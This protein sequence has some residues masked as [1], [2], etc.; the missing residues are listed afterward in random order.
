MGPVD[1][2]HQVQLNFTQNEKVLVQPDISMFLKGRSVD[3]PLISIVFHCESC[4]HW[5]GPQFLSFLARMARSPLLSP[6]SRLPA[7]K[8]QET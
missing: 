5:L 1:S 7:A 2:E 3:P 4:S 6:G 8:V